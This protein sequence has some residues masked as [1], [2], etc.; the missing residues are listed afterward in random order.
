MR[1]LVKLYTLR[2][3]CGACNRLCMENKGSFLIVHVHNGIASENGFVDSQSICWLV[4]ELK[5][6]NNKLQLRGYIGK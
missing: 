5:E 3:H 1:S 6:I 4:Q 2:R